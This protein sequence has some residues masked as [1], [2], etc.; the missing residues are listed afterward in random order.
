M[1]TRQLTEA[2]RQDI[3][4]RYGVLCNV[5][6]ATVYKPGAM[7]DWE[8]IMGKKARQLAKVR[9]RIAEANRRRAGR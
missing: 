3:A 9:Q 2:E 6:E 1:Q 5:T 4:M 7:N 8:D